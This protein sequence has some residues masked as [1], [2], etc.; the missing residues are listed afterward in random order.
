MELLQITT[1]LEYSDQLNNLKQNCVLL[2]D[3]IR[4]VFNGIVP[5][6]NE[7]SRCPGKSSK[8][9]LLSRILDNPSRM[10]LILKLYQKLNFF[11]I[12]ITYDNI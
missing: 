9:T 2:R 4:P 11:S 10:Y 8:I 6:L 5:Y 1:R 12:P 3:P 7:A